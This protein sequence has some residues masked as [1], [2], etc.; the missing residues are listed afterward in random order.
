M[1]LKI[2]FAKE[3]GYAGAGAAA[4]PSAPVGEAPDAS[5]PGSGGFSLEALE[6]DEE[7]GRVF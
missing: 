2:K 5:L 3:G 4:A 6:E 7:P 1:R